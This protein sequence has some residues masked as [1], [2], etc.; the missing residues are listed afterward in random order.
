MKN[1]Q[2][3]DEIV[4]RTEEIMQAF[5]GDEETSYIFTADHGMSAIGN[6]GDGRV[7]L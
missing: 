6:H 5:Y 1:I 2:A 7:Y 4:K 3:V